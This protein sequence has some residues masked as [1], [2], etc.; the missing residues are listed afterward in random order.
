MILTKAIK[1]KKHWPFLV[2]AGRKEQR[3]WVAGGATK[4]TRNRKRKDDKRWELI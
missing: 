1:S 3:L 4:K 2:F